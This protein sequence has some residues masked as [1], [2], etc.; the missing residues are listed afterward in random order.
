MGAQLLPT[1]RPVEAALVLTL[2]ETRATWTG[3]TSLYNDAHTMALHH[4]IRDDAAP[5][6]VQATTDKK[7]NRT[8]TKWTGP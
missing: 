1:L 4:H 2:V 8:A 7:H 5:L 6:H 3:H